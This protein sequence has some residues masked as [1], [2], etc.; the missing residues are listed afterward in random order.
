L[1]LPSSYQDLAIHFFVHFHAVPDRM[2]VYRDGGSD[3][4]FDKIRDEEVPAV[5]EAICEM[6]RSGN[7]SC[8]NDCEKRNCEACAP[9]ITFVV[10]QK[11]HNMRIV[12]SDDREAVNGNVPSGTL[13]DGYITSYEGMDETFDFLLVPQG[14]LKGTSKPM[15]YRVISNENAK[16]VV[17]HEGQSTPLTKEKFFEITYNMAFQCTFESR[18]GAF[19]YAP[20]S[21]FLC[22]KD[23]TATK[24]PRKVPVL[25]NS[26]KLSNRVIKYGGYLGLLRNTELQPDEESPHKIV[27]T[28]VSERVFPCSLYLA[29]SMY[30]LSHATIFLTARRPTSKGPAFHRIWML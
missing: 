25:L 1:L 30:L 20:H 19:S 18:V 9:K 26:E 4:S 3:G 12:P 13:V 17:G 27:R 28:D 22:S 29:H 11:D 21:C 6:N 8:P 24:A 14:G 16:P 7:R 2:I 10:A 15:H 23:G 5:R